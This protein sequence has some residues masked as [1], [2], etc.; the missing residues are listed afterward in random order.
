[1][2][3][4]RLT[5]SASRTAVRYLSEDEFISQFSELIACAGD[6]GLPPG[7]VLVEGLDEQSRV[8]WRAHYASA[9]GL[10]Q[11]H[12]Q[13]CEEREIRLRRAQLNQGRDG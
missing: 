3:M 9:H 8:A 10:A 7:P 13:L 2:T 11:L 5:W 4:L 12:R 1:M 6:G